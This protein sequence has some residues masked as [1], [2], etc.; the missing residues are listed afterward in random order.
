MH[1]RM[2]N[3]ESGAVVSAELI[4]IVTLTFCAAAVGW[5]TI[6]SAVVSELNDISEMIG[7][8][9]QSYSYATLSAPAGGL[10]ANHGT[11]TGSGFIDMDDECDCRPLNHV[12]VAGKTQT[13]AQ[14]GGAGT[15]ENGV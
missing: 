14:T 11:S 10:C 6:N 1:K 5:S 15:G 3:D 2:L 9:D 13:S 7:V 8:V 4:L 12:D